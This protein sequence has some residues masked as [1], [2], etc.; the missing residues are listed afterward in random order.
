MIDGMCGLNASDIVHRSRSEGV[1]L[2]P[3]HIVNV[4]TRDTHE[5][6]ANGALAALDLMD[7]VRVCQ[8]PVTR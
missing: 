7:R 1:P 6:A 5:E 3:V 4:E 8:Y 2:A